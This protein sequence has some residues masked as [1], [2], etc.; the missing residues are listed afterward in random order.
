MAGV[1][2]VR[3]KAVELLGVG[4]VGSVM[5][6]ASALSDHGKTWW[7]RIT[8]GQVN[9]KGHASATTSLALVQEVTNFE[10]NLIGAQVSLALLCSNLAV[11]SVVA[12]GQNLS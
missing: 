7:P 2:L 11:V 6:L 12:R 9:S 4:G 3:C 1:A 5:E 10:G 8:E